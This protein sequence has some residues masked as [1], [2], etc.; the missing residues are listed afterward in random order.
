MCEMKPSACKL[1]LM[2]VGR[3]LKKVHREIGIHIPS[4]PVRKRAIAADIRATRIYIRV[5]V[6]DSREIGIFSQE[7][8]TDSQEIAADSQEMTVN[9][10]EIAGYARRNAAAAVR[11]LPAARFAPV[12]GRNPFIFPFA[13]SRA[14]NTRRP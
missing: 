12:S 13:A 5:T 2:D 4:I 3:G 10:E 11:R 7:I 1:I 8:A 14:L 6:A 9:I